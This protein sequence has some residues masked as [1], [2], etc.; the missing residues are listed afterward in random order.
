N[1]NSNKYDNVSSNKYEYNNDTGY[2]Y[3][4]YAITDSVMTKS[5]S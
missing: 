3:D 2:E 5:R 1:K 4:N